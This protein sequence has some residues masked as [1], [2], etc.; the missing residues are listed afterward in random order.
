M[1][2]ATLVNKDVAAINQGRHV[3][4]ITVNPKETQDRNITL[5]SESS[6]T[7]ATH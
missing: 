4:S 6:D 1:S 2:P 7:T 5:P 3:L